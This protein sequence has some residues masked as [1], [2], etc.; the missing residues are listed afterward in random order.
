MSFAL[1]ILELWHW[2]GPS[3]VRKPTLR[4]GRPPGGP[5]IC[6]RPSI[7]YVAHGGT[8]LRVERGTGQISM[9]AD[10]HPINVCRLNGAET[11]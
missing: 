3:L 10:E 2:Q 6:G 9:P 7:V 1:S 5:G 4:S 8:T 11:I